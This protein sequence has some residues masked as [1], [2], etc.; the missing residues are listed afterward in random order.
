MPS[1][2]DLS[3]YVLL[4]LMEILAGFSLVVGSSLLDITSL[5]Y[6][7]FWLFLLVSLAGLT[8]GL[9]VS[10]FGRGGRT[11]RLVL[12]AA[13]VVCAGL[14]AYATAHDVPA[15]LI[16]AMLLGL[17]YWRGLSLSQ[18]TPDFGEVRSRFGL[19]FGLLFLGLMWVIARGI[20]YHRAIWY[21]LAL[22]GVAYTILAMV[23]LVVARLER[24]R[25]PG[26][27]GAVLLAVSL[28]L[29]ILF[30]LAVVA[31]QI[32]AL[33]IAGAL[34]QFTRP[35]WDTIG[36]A[37]FH[38]VTLLEGPVQGFVALLG[39]SATHTTHPHIPILSTSPQLNGKRHRALPPTS[40][41][42]IAL[43]ALAFILALLAGI[44][45][46]IW[47][48][49]ARLPRRV[50]E[51]GFVEQRESLWTVGDVWQALLAWLR[52][53]FRQGG[54]AATGA[55]QRTRRRLF[56]AYPADP[57][58][59]TYV[60]LLRRAAAA[61]APRAPGITPIEHRDRLTARWP[62]VAFEIT[63]LTDAYV[64]RRYG[65]VPADAGAIARVHDHWREIR[66]VIRV[67][68]GVRPVAEDAE[69]APSTAGSIS[70]EPWYRG[71]AALAAEPDGGAVPTL[72]LLAVCLIVP[73]VVIIILIVLVTFVGT[74]SGLPLPPRLPA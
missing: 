63:E 44:G 68:R 18:E 30:L 24:R 46:L 48:S 13:G 8:V 72:L 33:D 53:L 34:W 47:R 17:I 28:Q 27:G 42:L 51:R 74:H 7:S 39:S 62:A 59:R 58:R 36:A 49:L 65:D 64:L 41:P 1:P 45:Y 55:V 21:M 73:T 35:V 9:L 5:G 29:G 26:S 3:I 20:A 14:P 69:P 54:A 61:G 6:A 52:S 67:P 10:A 57:V 4:V 11:S 12:V 50:P 31:L 40:H 70:R 43:A 22:I 32:F 60:Q 38:L 15:L 25:E 37:G 23:A 2:R 19:G 16:T 66:R 56:G 71:L